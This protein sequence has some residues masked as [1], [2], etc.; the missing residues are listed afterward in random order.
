MCQKL[1]ELVKIKEFQN[2]IQK[3]TFLD[4]L[5][6]KYI[7]YIDFAFDDMFIKEYDF[8]KF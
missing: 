5:I 6:E 8:K 2:K 1:G 4:K 3:L 7:S